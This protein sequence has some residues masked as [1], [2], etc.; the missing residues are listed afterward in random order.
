MGCHT[1]VVYTFRVQDCIQDNTGD[2]LQG[3][4]YKTTRMLMFR[5]RL[6]TTLQRKLEGQRK[7]SMRLGVTC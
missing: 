3:M 7:P 5:E 2:T 6:Y 4:D 1:S